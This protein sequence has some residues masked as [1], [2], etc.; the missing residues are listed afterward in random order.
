MRRSDI[1]RWAAKRLQHTPRPKGFVVR[2][3]DM[4]VEAFQPHEHAEIS[5]FCRPGDVIMAIMPDDSVGLTYRVEDGP[6][7]GTGGMAGTLV[8][9]VGEQVGK[10]HEGVIAGYEAVISSMRRDLARKDDEIDRLHQRLERAEGK[11]IELV[12]LEHESRRMEHE[13]KIEESKVRHNQE[14]TDE[15][16]GRAFT[17]LDQVVDG[18][19]KHHSRRDRLKAMFEKLSPETLRAVMGD[20]TEDDVNELMALADDLDKEE[21]FSSTPKQPKKLSN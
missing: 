14:L 11:S 2:R 7:D 8:K 3:G 21:K 10:S 18:Y 6:D 19:L 16:L 17:V 5:G 12:R 20:L 13:Q 9:V 4:D 1:D 15:Y